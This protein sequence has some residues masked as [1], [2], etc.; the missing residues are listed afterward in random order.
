[1]EQELEIFENGNYKNIYPRTRYKRA[2][3]K[4]VIDNGKKVVAFQGLEDGNHIIVE[5]SG[6]AEGKKIERPEFTLYVCGVKYKDEMVSFALYEND[7]AKFASAGGVGDK[8]KISCKKELVVNLKTGVENM[9]DKLYFEK[10][11]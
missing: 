5:K 8:V 4:V 3:G 9:V 1:M 10:V 11:E 7:H 2:G 6:F